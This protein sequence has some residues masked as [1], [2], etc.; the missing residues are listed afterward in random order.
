M[1]FLITLG[2]DQLFK[3]V[4]LAA[5]AAG[6]LASVAGRGTLAYFTT[7]VTSTG[8]QFSAGNLHFNINDNNQ[9]GA[10]L[11]TVT[12]SITL[13]NM[14]PGDIVFA[15]ITVKNVGSIDAQWGV[16]YAATAG[17]S[18]LTPV[19]QIALV[20]RG[21]GNGA[22]AD[23]QA[24][25]S[26]FGSSTKWVERIAPTLATL[27]A[28]QTYVSATSTVAPQTPGAW[29]ATDTTNNAHLVME[30][31]GASSGL[32]TDILC[33]EVKWPDGGLP[34][35]LTTE[36][37]QYNAASAGTWSTTI[38]FTFDGQQ[39]NR[40]VEFDQPTAPTTGNY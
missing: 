18:D 10:G 27:Q 29:G 6:V 34:T 31:S 33:V 7:Q 16:K 22:Y 28:A 13:S 21:S 20:G 30:H 14:K 15:P 25:A 23:C 26:N 17:S 9:T 4:L 19:L 1:S 35:S 39:L 3:L 24:G 38:V 36:D 8:N 37:N 5:L 12:S 40:N 32:D 11:T 2:R